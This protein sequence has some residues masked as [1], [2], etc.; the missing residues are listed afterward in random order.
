MLKPIKLI[1]ICLGLTIFGTALAAAPEPSSIS[2]N[3][4]TQIIETK[5]FYDKIRENIGI[6][7]FSFFYGP[8]LH[9]DNI[10][11]SPNQLGRPE[12]DGIS[13]QNQFSMRYKFSNNLALDFQNRF[14]V[15]L[16]NGADANNFSVLRWEAPR[17]GLSGKLMSGSDW[18]LVGAVNTD[19][20]YFLPAPLTGYQAQ[21]RTVIFNPGMFANFRYEPKHSRWSIFSVVTP[22]YFFYSDRSAAEPQ[23]NKSGFHAQSKPELIIAFQPTVNYRL[24]EQLKLTMG[25]TVDYRKQVSSEWNIFNAS[26]QSNGEGKAWRLYAIPLSLGMSYTVASY[27][28]IFPFIST[29]PI[30]IQR[31]DAVTYKQASILEASS[32]G[33]WIHGTI[34]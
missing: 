17:I 7:Y 18:S 24:T 30:A 23:L 6:T 31:K 4:T 33:M 2:L 3:Q 9:P 14:R 12:N 32:F 8:G 34:F 10:A 5:S 25:S 16:N 19:F 1:E 26:L 27:L 29:Y 22:R 15:F 11:I 28:T 20:P 13:V 21:Q